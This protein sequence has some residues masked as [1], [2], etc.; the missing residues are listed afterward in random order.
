MKDESQITELMGESESKE[1]VNDF[2][3]GFDVKKMIV[4]SEIMKPKFDD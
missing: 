1:K 3:E 2:L 4:Y